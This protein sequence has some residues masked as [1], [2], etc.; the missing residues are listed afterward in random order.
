M[1]IVSIMIEIA[2]QNLNPKMDW[3]AL[4]RCWAEQY[5]EDYGN[6]FPARS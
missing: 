4:D 5:E 6:L 3:N 2:K 1:I